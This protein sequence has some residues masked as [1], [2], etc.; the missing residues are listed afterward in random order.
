MST[1]L[2]IDFYHFSG[3]TIFAPKVFL[4]RALARTMGKN[5]EVQK[6]QENGNVQDLHEPWH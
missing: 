2:K 3:S 1:Y 6:V 5:N 4:W